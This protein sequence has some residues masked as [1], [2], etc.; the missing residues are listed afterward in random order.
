MRVLVTGTDGQVGGELMALS[1]TGCELIAVDRG[2]MDLA[3]A[4]SIKCAF[5]DICPDLV[6][7][8]AAYTAVDLA[9]EQEEIAFAVNAEGPNVLAQLCAKA[10]IP[11][12]HLS[13]DYV[14][15]G[16]KTDA[17]VPDDPVHPVCVY[18]VS[19]EAGEC[20]VRENC[21][22]HLI[23]RTAWVFSARG[24]NFV[25]TMLDVGKKSDHLRVVMDQVGSPTSAKDVAQAIVVVIES[26]R[27]RE[28]PWGTYHFCN[29]GTATWYAFAEAIFEIVEGSWGHRPKVLPISAR[30]YPTPALRPLNSVLNTTAFAKAFNLTPRPWRD[31]LTDTLDE[32]M[33]GLEE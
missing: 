8:C 30:D 20:A 13:T 25:K 23:L 22:Q 2:V 18:G 5:A 17:Y 14:F 29:A 9:E 4:L 27:D 12:I 16:T 19:K 3:D 33:T 10:N 6:V 26:I 7:N 28:I 24:K 21:P 31:A 32:L 15:D 11:I 1:I